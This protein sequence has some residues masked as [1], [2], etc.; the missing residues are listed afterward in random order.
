MEETRLKIGFYNPYFDVPSGGER[1]TLTL[2]EHWSKRHNVSLFWDDPNVMGIS[3]KRFGLDLSQVSVVPNI[4]RNANIFGKLWET[5]KY[6]V[7][8]FLSDGSIPTTLARHNILHF[9]VPFPE[10]L[11]DPLK[12]KKYDV[13]V[14][15]SQFTK[16]ELDPGVGER[17][18]VIYP[19]VQRVKES[20]KV[21]RKKQILSVGR[22][23]SYFDAKKQDTLISAFAKAHEDH[24]FPSWELVLAGP[25]ISSDEEYFTRLQ[26]RIGTLPV[27]LLPNITNAELNKL[28]R[29]SSFYWHAAGFGETDPRHMEHFGITTVEAM[30]AGTVP[31][32]YAA[33]GQLEIVTDSV[34]GM[35]WKTEEELIQKTSA[36]IS[37]RESYRAIAKAARVR[38]EDFSED[39]FTR[40]YDAL[41]AGWR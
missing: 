3:E 8:F 7:I 41:I 6:D 34:N 20:S 22:F 26:K 32:V 17:A 10:V 29:E 9:Q 33:G 18:V 38:S 27:R 15:N 19:P 13:I 31:L 5:K 16:R 40:A 4:F 11:T 2:A 14:T 12:M 39:R 24:A 1:Y 23:T 37:D 35:L 25:L 21:M 36:L 28:Y 30:S